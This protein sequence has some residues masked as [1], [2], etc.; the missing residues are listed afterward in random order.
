M[1]TTNNQV[2]SDAV[3]ALN[4]QNAEA[5]QNEAV[6]LINAIGREQD[7]VKE[8]N[9]RMAVLRADLIKIA[10]TVIS[11]TSVLGGSLPSNANRETIAAVIEKANKQRQYEIETSSGRLTAA[12]TAEQDAV[13]MLEKRI[14]DLRDQLLKLSV[15]PVTVAQ[16]VG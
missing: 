11:E 1:N 13:V 3:A 5:L 2:V 16:I 4:Q 12:I 6:R 15:Q 9:D 8:A 7:K 14:A 10:S